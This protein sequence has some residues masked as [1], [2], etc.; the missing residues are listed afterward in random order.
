VRL[1][2]VFQ[3]GMAWFRPDQNAARR[4]EGSPMASA[5]FGNSVSILRASGKDHI[6]DCSLRTPRTSA[7][8]GKDEGKIGASAHC[9]RAIARKR[10]RRGD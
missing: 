9:S 8:T 10:W 6:D 3:E 7:V 2:S 1:R 5:A 4:D